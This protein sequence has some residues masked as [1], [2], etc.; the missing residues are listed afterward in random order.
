MRCRFPGHCVEVGI[1]GGST[2]QLANVVW[3]CFVVVI[4]Q[5]ILLLITEYLHLDIEP[6]VHHTTLLGSYVRPRSPPAFHFLI[7][8]FSPIGP[9][10]DREW[11]ARAV[12]EWDS[13]LHLQVVCAKCPKS[14]NLRFLAHIVCCKLLSIH[15]RCFAFFSHFAAQFHIPHSFFVQSH[16]FIAVRRHV[17]RY[18]D[19]MWN[20]FYPFTVSTWVCASIMLLAQLL[21][22]ALITNAESR[23]CQRP[24]FN[25]FQVRFLTNDGETNQSI[26]QMN[27]CQILWRMFRVQLQQPDG[28]R[29]YSM[30][31]W[32]NDA[33]FVWNG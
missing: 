2:Y 3:L 30:S 28:V 8:R 16:S 23:I 1:G 31:G 25:E 5:K 20:L 9:E 22:F 29:F 12:G 13:G 19:G 14:S 18:R 26:H 21:V 10:W 17:G 33:F 27:L 4:C 6:F 32:T 15:H 11:F 24:T 7:L